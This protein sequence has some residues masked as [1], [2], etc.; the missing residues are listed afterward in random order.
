MKNK[1]NIILVL[2]LTVITLF[3]NSQTRLV[4]A[5]ESKIVEYPHKA[6]LLMD[7]N[8][9]IVLEASKQDE[10]LE[11]ASIVKL[12][13]ILLTLEAIDKD[14]LKLDDKIESITFVLKVI[15]D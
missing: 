6:Y 5:D 4:Y 2:L 9:D 11:V 1:F 3:A 8:T 14:E 12:M 7:Y 10:K 15:Q 13:T